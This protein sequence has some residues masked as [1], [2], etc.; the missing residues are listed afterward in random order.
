MRD[1]L[2][3]CFL[4]IAIAMAMSFALCFTVVYAW[5]RVNRWFDG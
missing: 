3:G 2:H 5:D 1:F 4:P